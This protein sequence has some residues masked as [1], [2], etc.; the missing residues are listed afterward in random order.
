MCFGKEWTNK[1]TLDPF[2]IVY[3]VIYLITPF[4]NIGVYKT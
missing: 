1:L 3:D 2:S 4:Q